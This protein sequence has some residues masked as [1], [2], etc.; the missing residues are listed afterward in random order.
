M[1]NTPKN[2]YTLKK[3]KMILHELFVNYEDV[4]ESSKDLSIRSEIYNMLFPHLFSRKFPCPFPSFTFPCICEN[5]GGRLFVKKVVKVLDI[6]TSNRRVF[7]I[8]DREVGRN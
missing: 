3:G 8:R 2:I 6:H 7:C 4:N 5:A 1:G